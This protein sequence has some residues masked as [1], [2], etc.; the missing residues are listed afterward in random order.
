MGRM[1]RLE[2]IFADD[3]PHGFNEANCW[4]LRRLFALFLLWIILAIIMILSSFGFLGVLYTIS[5]ILWIA[6]DRESFFNCSA[7]SHY[8]DDTTQRVVILPGTQLCQYHLNHYERLVCWFLLFAVFVPT[9]LYMIRAFKSQ[10]FI[11]NLR[12]KAAAVK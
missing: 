2:F 5:S 3:N 6:I 11:D 1:E 10:Q 12:V 7:R 9:C 8:F 4:L